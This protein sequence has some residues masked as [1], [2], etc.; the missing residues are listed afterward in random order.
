MIGEV[1]LLSYRNLWRHPR[2]TI[3]TSIAI[4]IGIAALIWIHSML[5]WAN[6]KSVRNLIEYETGN[7]TIMRKDYKKEREDFPVDKAMS[8]EIV[9]KVMKIA[10]EI[11][12]YAAP[13]TAFM[14]VV[15][16]NRGFGLP[17]VV[18]AIDPALDSKVFKI[19]ESIVEGK[20]L[21]E[22]S[23]GILISSTLKDQLGVKLGD[24]ITVE[25][26]TRYNTY[27][28][29]MLK[30]TGIYETP[31]PVVDMNQ[32]FIT[33]KVAE[34]QLQMEGSSTMIAFRSPDERDEPYL[35]EV[36]RLL[37]R[38]GLSN[39][40]ILTWREYGKDYLAASEGDKGSSVIIILF[41]FI[42]VAIGIINT[43]LMAVYERVKE[44]GM[45]RSLG[46][47]EKY[48]MLSFMFEAGGIG[49]IGSLIGLVL[50][51]ILD[52][53]M[54]YHGIDFSSA[55]KGISYGYRVGTVWYGE[56]NPEMMVLAVLL[57]AGLSVIASYIPVRRAVKIEITEALRE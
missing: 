39:L 37:S 1:L 11:S 53:F 43:M 52:A 17:Y 20:Y 57:G 13:R 21:N 49:L 26:R 24:Y 5:K 25:T 9:D 34:G 7:F 56:W 46:L 29:L 32:L 10:K 12:C 23:D 47:K 30:V 41:I 3:I 50:G 4:G 44:V 45:L 8:R 31:D 19:K 28:V 27:Q 40:S 51:I 14:S 42:V 55:F 16:F 48:I 38:K 35:T 33:Q 15:S 2:R 54:V 6:D 18:Y 36:K 22:N